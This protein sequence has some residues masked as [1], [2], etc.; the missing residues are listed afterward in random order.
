MYVIIP[1]IH[2][3]LFSSPTEQS[4]G[5]SFSRI[6][7]VIEATTESEVS[8]LS[9]HNVELIRTIFIHISF[10]GLSTWED[11]SGEPIN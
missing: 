3:P 10:K 1:F 8:F 5:Q 2:V 6:A 11:K 4:F 9:D 7:D